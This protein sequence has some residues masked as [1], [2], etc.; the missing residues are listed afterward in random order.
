MRFLPENIDFA[1]Y[2]NVLAQIRYSPLDQH[3]GAKSF[4]RG[5]LDDGGS[6]TFVLHRDTV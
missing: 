2:F 6:Y 1:T 5:Y 3:C 4:C